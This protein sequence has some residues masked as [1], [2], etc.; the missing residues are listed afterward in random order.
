MT[1]P[2]YPGG[3]R[4]PTSATRR[5]VAARRIRARAASVRWNDV[6]SRAVSDV[7]PDAGSDHPNPDMPTPADLVDDPDYRAAVVDLLGVLAYTELVAFERLA[8]DAS[9]APTIS[10]EA[11]L[12]LMATAEIRHFTRLAERL[13]ELGADPATAMEPFVVPITEFHEKTAPG[14]WLESLVKAYVGDGIAT[15][16]YREIANVLDPET[17]ELVLDVCSDTGHANFAVATVRAAIE[18]DPRIGGRLALWGRRLVGEAMSQ[19][20][21]VAAERDGLAS[22]IVGGVDRPGMGLTELGAMFSRLT[23]AHTRRM[24]TLGLQA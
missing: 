5:I 23:E 9:L 22:L 17:R 4:F 15:D 7:T 21:T 3:G 8:A 18:A 1:G 10:D 16:F 2:V 14:D 11:A 24:Q 12:A 19:A 20:Q 6:R 13:A